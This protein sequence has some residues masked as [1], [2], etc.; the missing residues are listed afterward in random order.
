MLQTLM[1]RECFLSPSMANVFGR[2]PTQEAVVGCEVL[3]QVTQL[4]FDSDLGA[5]VL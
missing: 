5:Q 2:L 3:G 1:T 4:K